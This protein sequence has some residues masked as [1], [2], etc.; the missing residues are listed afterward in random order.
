VPATPRPPAW[1]ALVAYAVGFFATLAAST[2]LLLAV[3]A[4]RV[5]GPWPAILEEAQRFAVSGAGLTAQAALS[6]AALAAVAAAGAR[7]LGP[8]IAAQLRLGTTRASALGGAAAVVGTVGLSLSCGA[9]TDLLGARR[10]V[11]MEGIS[12]AMRTQGYSAF[13]LAVVAI[14]V[15]PAI[16]EEAFFRGLIQGRLVAAWGRVPGI[17]GAALTFGLIH[18][19]PVHMTL[20][21]V[22]GLFL[23]WAAERLGGIR[24]TMLAHAVNNSMFLALAMLQPADVSSRVARIVALCGGV[25]VWAAATAVLSSRLALR[26][27]GDG[28]SRVRARGV[29]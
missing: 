29:P 17:V 27:E 10:G 1:P 13:V 4:A 14:G 3:G 26:S 20:A 7:L 21:L 5:R 9:A 24:P 6:A 19:D 8:D 16:A 2:G 25:I 11:V 28:P 12:R 15:A 22:A 18:I 23:G